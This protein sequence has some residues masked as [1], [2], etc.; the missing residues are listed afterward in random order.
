[1]DKKPE[2]PCPHCDKL[3]IRCSGACLEWE[4]WFRAEWR[5][6]Q[7]LYLGEKSTGERRYN[8]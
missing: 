4:T 7:T 3:S 2:H 1:M 6:L 5:R 8:Q